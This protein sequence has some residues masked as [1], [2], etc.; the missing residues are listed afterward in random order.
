MIAVHGIHGDVTAWGIDKSSLKTTSNCW[1]SVNFENARVMTF[2]YETDHEKSQCYTRL[3]VYG[4]AMNLL[5]DI[6]Q[7]REGVSCVRYYA[8]LL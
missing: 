8:Y 7:H 5:V 3:G 2:N 4:L 1:L 6:Q